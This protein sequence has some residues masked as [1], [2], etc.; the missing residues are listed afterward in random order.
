MGL[1]DARA[2]APRLPE[3]QPAA[4]AAPAAPASLRSRLLLPGEARERAGPDCETADIQ[5]NSRGYSR[6]KVT[7]HDRL[8]RAATLDRERESLTRATPSPPIPVLL[9]TPPCLVVAI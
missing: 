9:Y 6:T 3:R 1:T 5:A 4:P 2:A 7:C 8:D